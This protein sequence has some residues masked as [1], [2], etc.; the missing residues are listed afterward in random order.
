MSEGGKAAV[1]GDDQAVSAS[2][3]RALKKQVR[4]YL[5]VHRPDAEICQLNFLEP[6]GD[7]LHRLTNCSCSKKRLRNEVYAE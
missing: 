5:Y 3:L 4:D 6:V 1:Q 2:E 7:D